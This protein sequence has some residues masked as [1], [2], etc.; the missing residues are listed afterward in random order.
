MPRG[1]V[2]NPR[3][4]VDYIRAPVAVCQLVIIMHFGMP[5]V[6]TPMPSDDMRATL[7]V[8]CW[9]QGSIPFDLDRDA[10]KA[11]VAAVTACNYALLDDLV[12]WLG[13]PGFDQWLTCHAPEITQAGLRL[14]VLRYDLPR[15]L[16]DSG[17]CPDTS[18][19][20]PEDAETYGLRMLQPVEQAPPPG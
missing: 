8:L 16:I 11:F 15:E 2:N 1:F 12:A 7:A 6:L 4:L 18:W 3:A 14:A 20:V 19:R 10:P 17:Y 5:S 13:R 9:D